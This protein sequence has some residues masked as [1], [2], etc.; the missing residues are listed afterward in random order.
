VDDYVDPVSGRIVQLPTGWDTY[1]VNAQGEY[2]AVGAGA[3]DP[4]EL[5]AGGWQPLVPRQGG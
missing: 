3:I 1:W 2:L 4:S 5:A